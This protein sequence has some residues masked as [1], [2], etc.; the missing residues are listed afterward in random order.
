MLI[1]K[2]FWPASLGEGRGTAEGG[3]GGQGVRRAG[4]GHG[5]ATREARPR[6]GGLDGV[7]QFFQDRGLYGPSRAWSS[8]ASTWQVR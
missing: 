3:A 7:G 4:G 1:V 6:L 2:A 5:H 8:G